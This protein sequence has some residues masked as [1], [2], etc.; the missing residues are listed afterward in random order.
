MKTILATACTAALALGFAVPAGAFES[1]GSD[2]VRADIGATVL[3]APAEYDRKGRKKP[4]IPG[5]SGCDDPEDLIEHPEC[6]G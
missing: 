2:A 3:I 1:S 4:R 6:A 5:G